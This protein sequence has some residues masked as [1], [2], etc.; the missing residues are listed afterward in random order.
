MEDRR[1]HDRIDVIEQDMKRHREE[2]ERFEKALTENTILTQTIA[3]NT[4]E[5]V[6]IIKGAKGL[7]SFVIWA[8]PIAAA[9]AG[10]YAYFKGN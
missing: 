3:S 5:L 2:H 9:I 8:A 4:T 10:T 7:R 6:E 1:A